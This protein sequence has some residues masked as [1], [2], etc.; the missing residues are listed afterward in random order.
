MTSETEIV[1]TDVR[2]SK[3]ARESAPYPQ[4]C[5]SEADSL[6]KK[7]MRMEP[8]RREREEI[9][10]SLPGGKPNIFSKRS[11]CSP[12]A[13]ASVRSHHVLIRESVSESLLPREWGMAY[14][15]AERERARRE[16]SQ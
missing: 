9:N 16:A 6:C 14:A 3:P 10:L 4:T 1:V 2:A 11:S 7:W 8:G 5:V 13:G 12:S 15:V